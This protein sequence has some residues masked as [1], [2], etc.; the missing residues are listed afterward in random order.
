VEASHDRG[1]P[2]AY[3]GRAVDFVRAAGREANDAPVFLFV[4]YMRVHSPYTPPPRTNRFLPASTPS[5]PIG[6]RRLLDLAKEL[7]A[8][9]RTLSNADRDSLIALYDAEIRAM[10]DDFRRLVE[11]IDRELPRDTIVIL[12]SD[13]GEEFLEH[14][15]LLHGSTLYDEVLRVPLIVVGADVP[16]NLRVDE[17]VSLLDIVPTVLEWAGAEPRTPLDGR[18][19]VGFF[20]ARQRRDGEA[21]G[22]HDRWPLALQTFAHDGRVRL[23]GVRGEREKLIVDDRARRRELYDLA[24]DPNEKVNRYDG[25]SSAT[26]LEAFLDAQTA[27]V[28]A[29]AAPASK[30]DIEALKSLGYLQ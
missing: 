23:R 11:A 4:H 2:D 14:G 21:G 6:G 27:T 20:G 22:R 1:G 30:G 26:A 8:G 5:A 10:D 15:H 12:T 9:T 17:P 18:S 29:A 7:E 24:V 3:A 19:L 16:R 13:H 28:S 25:V